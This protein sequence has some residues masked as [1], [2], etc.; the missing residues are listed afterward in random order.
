VG[1]RRRQQLGLIDPHS[2]HRLA[3]NWGDSD[4]TQ[5]ATW[6]NIEGIG[7][8]DNGAVQSG[9]IDRVEILMLG[10]GECLVDN[11]EVL[12]AAGANQLAPGNSPSKQASATGCLRAIM[13]APLSS[14]PRATAAV[15]PCMCAPV[16][17]VT[18]GPTAF[19]APHQRH[20]GR[21]YRNYSR[22]GRW[23]R[24]W[25]E[26]VIRLKGNYLEATGRFNVPSSLGTPGAPNSRAVPNAGPAIYQVSHSPVVPAANTPVVVT[27]RA[28]D[29]D[30]LAS[31]VLKYRLDPSASYSTTNMVVMAPEATLSQ[32]MES[33]VRPF[34]ARLPELWSAFTSRQLTG[35][36]LQPQLYS[37]P[38]RPRRLRVSCPIWRSDAQHQLRRLSLLDDHE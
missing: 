38:T 37:R 15:S 19:A 35:P 10:E 5:K 11:V 6:T 3:Y 31:I 20:D 18:P 22:Q 34:P 36:R 30:G 33:T 4:D 25:P 17:A 29:P 21:R 26:I 2:N 32:E 9:G 7:T 23:L 12:N 14:Q 16:L 13:F 28:D 24:G 8:L 1:W 27:A